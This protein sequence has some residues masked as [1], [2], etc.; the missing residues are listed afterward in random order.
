MEYKYFADDLKTITT[1]RK[2]EIFQEIS[3][4]QGIVIFEN[5][6]PPEDGSFFS[7][8]ENI[9]AEELDEVH[10]SLYTKALK[11]PET[12]IPGGFARLRKKL[13]PKLKQL[14]RLWNPFS[15][16]NFQN[17]KITLEK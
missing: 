4:H 10:L 3:G 12:S 17:S 6:M 16:V 2:N 7:D 8:G 5:I 14:G 13:N 9:W 1:S 15:K 11:P